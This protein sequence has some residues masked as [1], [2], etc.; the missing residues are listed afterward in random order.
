[1]VEEEKDGVI[2]A[3]LLDGEP[4]ESSDLIPQRPPVHSIR[5][6]MFASRS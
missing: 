1:V 3:S 6:G 4:R 5:T 2:A